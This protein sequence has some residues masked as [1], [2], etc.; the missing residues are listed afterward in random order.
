MLSVYTRH[1][2]DCKNA[3]DKTWRRC[4]C[5][6][7]IWGSVNGNF[8]RRSAKTHNWDE[9]E[10]LRLRLMQAV[11]PPALPTPQAAELSPPVAPLAFPPPAV[12]AQAAGEALPPVPKRPR[13]TVKK[14]VEAYLADAVGRNVS[15]ATLEKLTTIFQKQFLPWAVAQGFEF[16]DEVELDALLN[17]R[18]TWKD[19]A[20]AKQKKQSRVSTDT[21]V[22][23]APQIL[24]GFLPRIENLDDIKPCSVL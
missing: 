13:V 9:A 14:A 4:S 7:W 17:F 23:D 1:H 18:S 19:G 3:G 2:P 22:P 5:P 15:E 11:T 8:I 6:K 10:E 16:I 12:Q 21:V 20:L 24:L